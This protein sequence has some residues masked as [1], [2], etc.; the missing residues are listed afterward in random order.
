MEEKLIIAIDGYSSSGKSTFAKAIAKEL[1]YIYIDSGAMYRAVTLYCLRKGL[2]NK[3]GIDVEGVKKAL[4][5]IHID[6]VYNPDS[7]E[8]E[9]WLNSENVEQEIR[10]IE[11]SKFVSLISQIPDVRKRM[12]ELQRE[13]GTHK[14]IVMDGRDIGTVVFPDADIK[15]FMTAS[16]D[17]RAQ[18][19]FDE[20]QAK[21]ESVDYREIK[22]NII[23]RDSMDENRA[24]SPLRK[25]KDAIILDNTNMTLEEQMSWIREVISRKRS[26]N[27]DRQ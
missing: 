14:G 4:K 12:V 25:A 1:N 21:K 2:I 24:V 20:L 22:K 10:S 26:E 23:E 8:Y 5:D 15:I 7:G 9:T 6:F 3:D 16:F 11:V 19:R 18:R 27:R 13:I 17:V